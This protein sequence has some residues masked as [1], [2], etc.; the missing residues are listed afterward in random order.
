ML[1]RAY[2]VDVGKVGT[3]HDCKLKVRMPLING[4]EDEKGSTADADLSWAAI[5]CIPGLDVQY[6]VGDVV[7]VGFEDNDLDYPIVLGHLKTNGKNINRGARVA[8][9]VQTLTVED[10]F[11]APTATIIG[12]TDYA[13]IFDN[14]NDK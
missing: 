3:P 6:V 4:V 13:A 10:R 12:K 5:M 11:N 2:V 7:I 1:T 9:N 8:G 14:I